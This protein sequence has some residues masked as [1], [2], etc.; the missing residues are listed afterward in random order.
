MNIVTPDEN[1]RPSI[2]SEDECHEEFI[3]DTGEDV[4]SSESIIEMDLDEFWGDTWKDVDMEHRKYIEF[5][6][7]SICSVFGFEKKIFKERYLKYL[8]EV[9]DEN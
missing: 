4:F 1:G 2:K 7:E 5:I 3:R 8:K 9:K 6:S